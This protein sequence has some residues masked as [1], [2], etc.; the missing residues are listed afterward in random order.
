MHSNKW[1]MEEQPVIKREKKRKSIFIAIYAD[2]FLV[3]ENIS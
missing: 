1:L 3:Y 2:L